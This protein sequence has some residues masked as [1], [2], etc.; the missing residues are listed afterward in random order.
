[1][2]IIYGAN[3]KSSE[4]IS[5]TAE[6]DYIYGRDGDDRIFGLE[7]DDYLFGENGN[8]TLLGHQGNDTLDGGAGNDT[9]WG[10]GGNDILT[11]GAGS[12]TFSWGRTSGDLHLN[13]TDTVTDFETGVDKI[14]LSHIDADEATAITR[15]RKEELG[16]E[17]FTYVTETDGITAGHLTLSYDPVSGYTTLNAYTNTVA[18]ADLTILI[19]G[20]VDPLTDFWL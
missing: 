13:G 4:D 11:G 7:G 16:N 9:L 6:I 8:D 5:G 14:N 19:F 2:A 17:A 3:R 15:T 20:Q 1:M 12:D 10:H 18:G